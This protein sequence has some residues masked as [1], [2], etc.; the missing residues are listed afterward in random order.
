[1]KDKEF[2]CDKN[3]ADLFIIYYVTM[4]LENKISKIPKKDTDIALISSKNSLGFRLPQAQ[5]TA[6]VRGRRQRH[7]KGPYLKVV[8]RY[9]VT[10]LT[11]LFNYESELKAVNV[12][13]FPWHLCYC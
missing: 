9:T 4:N 3:Y 5:R 13:M 1:M 8:F 11:W 10:V 7:S 12:C 2:T 6:M